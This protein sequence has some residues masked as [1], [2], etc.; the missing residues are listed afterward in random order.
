MFKELGP[1]A[2]FATP[3]KGIGLFTQVRAIVLSTL[4]VLSKATATL[5]TLERPFSI[6]GALVP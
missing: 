6:V 4:G 2:G 5:K 1:V 3:W